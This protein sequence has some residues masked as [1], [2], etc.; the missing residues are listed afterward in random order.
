MRQTR[1]SLV[2]CELDSIKK[3]V[4]NFSIKSVSRKLR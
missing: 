4:N 1:V 3:I 2:Y